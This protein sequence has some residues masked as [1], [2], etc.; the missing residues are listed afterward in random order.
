MDAK[1]RTLLHVYVNEW[2]QLT[3]CVTKPSFEVEVFGVRNTLRGSLSNKPW[4]EKRSW[5]LEGQEK[6]W[7]LLNQ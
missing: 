6:N 1:S 7:K 3:H 4:M 5:A 2:N